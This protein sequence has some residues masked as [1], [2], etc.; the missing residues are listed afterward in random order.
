MSST[1]AIENPVVTEKTIVNE[2]PVVIEKTVVNS[3]IAI[4]LA[5]ATILFTGYM[6]TADYW[7]GEAAFSVTRHIGALLGVLVAAAALH[8]VIEAWHKRYRLAAA[9]FF[10]L[11]LTATSLVMASAWKRNAETTEHARVQVVA[12]NA[13]RAS[14]R[15]VATDAMKQLDVARDAEAKA[16]TATADACRTGAGPMCNGARAYHA[17]QAATVDARQGEW[18]AAEAYVAALGP[19]AVVSPGIAS[20]VAFLALIGAIVD[21]ARTVAIVEQLLSLLPVLVF[22]IAAM[23]GITYG[24]KHT[25]TVAATVSATVAATVSATVSAT[26]AQARKTTVA[27]PQTSDKATMEMAAPSVKR[28]A[29]QQALV[30]PPTVVSNYVSGPDLLLKLLQE[31]RAA[32]KNDAEVEMTV[33]EAANVLRQNV[34]N[35]SKWRKQLEGRIL[36]RRS[37]R[38][39]YLSSKRKNAA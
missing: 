24:F 3:K 38:C 10:I 36:Q 33:T 22:E 1:L 39:L 15:V 13:A 34:Y 9:A 29:T 7:T 21:Q 25:T 14:A 12:D 30:I 20:A 16:S 17:T 8:L 28:R 27:D 32:A 37:G 31:R 6:I 11:S 18:R 26:V 5:A 23:A 2:N 4:A 19:D 35:V